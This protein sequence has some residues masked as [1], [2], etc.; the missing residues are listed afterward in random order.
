VKLGRKPLLTF[1]CPFLKKKFHNQEKDSKQPCPEDVVIQNA[2]N[3][4]GKEILKFPVIITP[5]IR[6]F[7]PDPLPGLKV[8]LSFLIK[9]LYL[10]LLFL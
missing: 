8:F 9:F 6:L 2:T 3:I 10:S 5:F 1:Y 7:F 4:S